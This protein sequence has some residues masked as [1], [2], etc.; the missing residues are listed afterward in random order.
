MAQGRELAAGLLGSARSKAEVES[1]LREITT[2]AA[3]NA[4]GDVG[5]GLS[6]LADGEVLSIGATSDSAQ[7][8]DHGQAHDGDGPCLHALSS[9]SAVSVTDYTTDSRWPGTA[10]RAADAGVRSSLSL[11]LKTGD[12]VLGAL[13]VYSDSPDAFGVAALLSLGAFADQATTSL[14]LLGELQEQRDDS[15]YVTAFSRTV[16]ESLR[17]VLPE[18][19]GL[20]LVGGSV[21]SASR[22]TV[23]GDW[24]D[25]LVL[26]DG[27]VG[28]VIGD[29]MGHGINA[30]TAMSQLR[31]MVRAGAWLGVSPGAVLDMTDELAEVAGITETA[32]LFYGQ[33]VRDGSR[34]QLRY[35]NAGH[36]LP[37]L[38]MPDGAVTA[39]DGGSRMLLG[40]LN[41]GA[42]PATASPTG[43]V[44]LPEGSLLLLYTDGLVERATATLEEATD[45]LSRTLS[46]FDSKQPLERLCQQLLQA[47]GAR[48]DTTVFTVRISG[49]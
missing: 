22:A 21:P 18:V 36:L 10:S 27:S 24:Y 34:A 2:R 47:P 19:A 5:V 23:G 45:A 17:T 29:V 44:E 12:L 28:L 48:D 26:P 37:L 41:T 8:M 43:V 4:A 16:Q 20:E 32:T 35:C 31:P 13:N 1:A 3:A 46:E 49:T 15:A 40:A 7:R 9:G 33:L 11:P 30:V 6:V 39:L 14:F 38:R 25:A 42:A